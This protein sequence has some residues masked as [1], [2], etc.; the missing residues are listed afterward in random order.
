V[1]ACGQITKKHLEDGM[2]IIKI[3]GVLLIACCATTGFAHSAQWPAG[4]YK[5]TKYP[6]E[7][8]TVD[9][10]S[11]NKVIF[12]SGQTKSAI[13]VC[14][15]GGAPTL[16]T[17]I[18]ITYLQDL[19]AG[20]TRPVVHDESLS[21]IGCMM[22]RACAVKVEALPE[23]GQVFQYMLTRLE[24]DSFSCQKYIGLRS[25]NDK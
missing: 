11:V 18:R 17:R 21:G 6:T 3:L 2:N 15:V 22:I 1:F 23:A 9:V 14:D 4:P 24:E 12:D 13:Y 25:P 20:G 7:Y 19:D 8:G 16:S 10:N 5:A